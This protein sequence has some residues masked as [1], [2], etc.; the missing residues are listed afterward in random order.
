MS[1][2]RIVLAVVLLAAGVGAA[3]VAADLR[4]FDDTVHAGDLRF[5]TDPE[6][7][8]WSTPT[9]VPADLALRILGLRDELAFRRAA[10]GFEAARTAGRGFDNGVSEV[11]TRGEVEGALTELEHGSNARRASAAHNLAGILAFSDASKSGSSAPAPIDRSVA[12]FQDAIRR[13]PANDDAKYNLELLLRQL[14]TKGLR[15][16][17][18]SV[19]GGPSHGRHGAGAGRPGHGY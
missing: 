7:A 5:L 8:R 19:A 15:P 16:G 17:S 18:N 13:D 2:L 14:V 11:R 1:R 6:G 10:Q 4:R 12:E 9:L 3:L